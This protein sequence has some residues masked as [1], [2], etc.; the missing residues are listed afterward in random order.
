M[1]DELVNRNQSLD[2][3]GIIGFGRFGRVL[4]KIL[5]DDFKVVAYDPSDVE[6]QF[7]VELTN[8]SNVPVEGVPVENN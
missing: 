6:P 4:G 1:S 5:S 2:S 8:Q 3:I 7:G